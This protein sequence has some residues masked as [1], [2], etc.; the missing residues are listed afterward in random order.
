MRKVN[1]FTENKELVRLIKIL[2]I[3]IRLYFYI[4]G[5]S[6]DKERHLALRI[7]FAHLKF[8]YL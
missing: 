5:Q 1:I 7:T 8:Y 4:I 6:L 3:L 2:N